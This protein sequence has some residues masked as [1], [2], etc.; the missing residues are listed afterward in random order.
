[1]KESSRVFG[2]DLMRC[3]AILLVLFSHSLWI[4]PSFSGILYDLL[5]IGGFLGVE[6]FF[7]LSGFLIGNILYKSWVVKGGGVRDGFYFLI[8]RWFRTLPNYYLFLLI[9]LILAYFLKYEVERKCSYVFFLQN[10]NT[11]MPSFFHETWSL[12]VE[13]WGYV[14]WALLLF[15]IGSKIKIFYRKRYFL[16]VILSMMIYGLFVRYGF[17]LD[18]SKINMSEWNVALKGVVIYRIDVLAWGVFG[19][20]LSFNYAS[21]WRKIRYVLML[22]GFVIFV[23]IFIGIGYFRLLIDA[24]PFF[25]IVLYLPIVSSMVFCFLPILSLWDE[26]KGLLPILIRYVSRISYAI[27]LV[28][29]SFVLWLMKFLFPTEHLSL[30]MLCLYTLVYWSIV[31]LISSMVYRFYEK[32]IMDLR[33]KFVP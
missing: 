19:S 31:F 8:K 5:T 3:V 23:M 27:Y 32:P 6:I 10:F 20:Y 24:Y 26:A 28:H 15:L 2:L 22:I 33:D 16:F 14:I 18:Q 9:N 17:Y 11:K 1:M 4:F 25:W 30:N 13:E 12:S 21:W 7:V 29:Y